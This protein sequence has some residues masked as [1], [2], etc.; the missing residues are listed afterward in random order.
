MQEIDR[1]NQLSDGAY[2]GHLNDN[3]FIAQKGNEIWQAAIHLCL[4]R[5]SLRK[6][7][8]HITG[9]HPGTGP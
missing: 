8:H 5:D 6:R 7:Q 9:P 3:A 2:D 1:T 4:V